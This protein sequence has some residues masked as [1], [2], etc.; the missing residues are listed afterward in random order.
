MPQMTR[1]S[2]IVCPATSV[3]EDM[4]P[5]AQHAPIDLMLVPLSRYG[6]CASVTMI[7]NFRRIILHRLPFVGTSLLQ[8]I[9]PGSFLRCSVVELEDTVTLGRAC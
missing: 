7:T 1:L 6:G 8:A 2:G 3:G 9:G 4:S 5:G